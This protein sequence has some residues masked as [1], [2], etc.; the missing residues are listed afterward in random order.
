MCLTVVSGS[1]LSCSVGQCVL[2]KVSDNIFYP[3]CQS[4]G[5]SFRDENTRELVVL[6]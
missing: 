4:T 1:V 5:M 3:Q 6:C 2:A